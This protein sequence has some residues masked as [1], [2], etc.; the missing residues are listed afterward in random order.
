MRVSVGVLILIVMDFSGTLEMAACRLL[1]GWI[2][3]A[4]LGEH[5]EIQFSLI[6]LPMLGTPLAF[7]A[8]SR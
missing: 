6:I 2:K 5:L 4:M 7:K 3:S 1:A 8:N